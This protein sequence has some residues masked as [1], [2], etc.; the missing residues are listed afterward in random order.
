MSET[1]KA[2]PYCGEQILPAA[3]KCKHCG[4]ALT[5]SPAVGSVT[6]A[7]A[8]KRQFTMGPAIAIPA[9]VLLGLLS[10]AAVDHW[11]QSVNGFSDADVTRIERNISIKL[12]AQRWNVVDV[13]LMRQ[14]QTKLVG[15]AKVRV[16]LLGIVT[17]PCTVNMGVD[18]STFWRCT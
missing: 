18:H 15:Y 17:K 7:A 1:T 12:S 4:S 3:I 6:P 10:L 5:G 8:L 9:V 2:C 11:R 13:E 16:P 14:T